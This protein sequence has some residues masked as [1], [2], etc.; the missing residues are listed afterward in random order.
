MAGS[1]TAIAFTPGVRAAQARHGSRASYARLEARASPDLLTARERAFIEARDG[2]VQATVTADGWPYV[3]HRGGPP[4]FL[5][6]LDE[7]RVAYADFSGNRQYL[8]VGN[9]ATDDRVALI[10]IDH[11]QRRRLKLWARA[12]IVEADED[13]DLVRSLMPD[14]YDA[15]AERAVIL[16]VEALDWNCPQHITPRFTAVE[17]EAM[18]AP[19]RDHIAALE[20]ELARLRR[21]APGA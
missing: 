17:I 10:L 11:A 14:G 13:P 3:Q 7:R 15:T 16:T 19:V 1:Y 8:S 2:F 9:L 18:L 12:R 21:A 6:V 20:A 4:G 5:V